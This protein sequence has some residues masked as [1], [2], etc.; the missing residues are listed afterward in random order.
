MDAID[1]GGEDNFCGDD[2]HGLAFEVVGDAFDDG[3]MV[4][5]ALLANANVGSKASLG[6]FFRTERG[7]IAGGG[8]GKAG[9][10][11]GEVEELGSGEGSD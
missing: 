4:K 2:A 10:A 3:G 5:E 8:F 9:E 7:E 1:A 6:L 11:A